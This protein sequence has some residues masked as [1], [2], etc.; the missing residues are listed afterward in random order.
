ME[1]VIIWWWRKYCANFQFIFRLIY[2]FIYSFFFFFLFD[3]SCLFLKFLS[4]FFLHTIVL[5]VSTT[6]PGHWKLRPLIVL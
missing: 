2:L 3:N 6:Y 5:M 4:N 1:V